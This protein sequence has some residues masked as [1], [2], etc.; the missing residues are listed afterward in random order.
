MLG[1]EFCLT[2]LLVRSDYYGADLDCQWIDVTDLPPG[3]YILRVEVNSARELPEETFEN[4]VLSVEV[5]I[6]P[7]P[8]LPKQLP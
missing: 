7:A 5:N 6:P 8:L 3:K 4:N 2:L 1:A